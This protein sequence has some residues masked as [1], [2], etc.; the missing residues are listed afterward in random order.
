MTWGI[1]TEYFPLIIEEELV[2]G[3]FVYIMYSPYGQGGEGPCSVAVIGGRR[4]PSWTV[5]GRD[6]SPWLLPLLLLLRLRS[7]HPQLLPRHHWLHPL[8]VQVESK[9]FRINDKVHPLHASKLF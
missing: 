1:C 8:L 5:R 3:G 2:E 9:M 6:N 4:G 7:Q